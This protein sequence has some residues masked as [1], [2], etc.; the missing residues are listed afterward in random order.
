LRRHGTPKK[1]EDLLKHNCM[2][3]SH[4]PA[5][6]RWPFETRDGVRHIEVGGNVVASTAESL[7]QLALLGVGVIRLSDAIVGAALAEG[8]LVAV[9]QDVHHAEPL[10][11]HAV[12][13][14]GRHRSPRVSAMIDF[15]TEKF[16]VRPRSRDPKR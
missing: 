14:H 10:P 11:L 16:G 5:L 4:S 8:K 13:P 2:S 9:L 3:I 6:R 1:P 12:Y 7:L 15:L